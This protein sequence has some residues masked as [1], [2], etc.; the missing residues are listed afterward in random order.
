[1]VDRIGDSIAL[2]NIGVRIS[3]CQELFYIPNYL[4]NFN[5]KGIM[6]LEI[7]GGKNPIK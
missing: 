4:D 7:F 6:L 5:Q 2:V 3:K 1:V